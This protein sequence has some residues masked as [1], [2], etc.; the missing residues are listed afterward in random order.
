MITGW[1]RLSR[2]IETH[3]IYKDPIKF[4]WWIDLLINV[5][6]KDSKINIGNQ[7]IEC[8]RGQSIMSLSS[9]GERWGVSK[10]KA[11]N[12]FLLLEKDGMITH[13]NVLKSTR[14]TI[15]NYESYQSDLHDSQTRSKR[16]PNAI[17]TQSHPLEKGEESKKFKKEEEVYRHFAHLTI[18]KTEFDKLIEEGNT[19][20]SIDDVLDSIENYKK[21]K[22]YTSLYLTAKK[23]LKSEREKLSSQPSFKPSENKGHVPPSKYGPDFDPSKQRF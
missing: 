2:S 11:R 7:L 16:K 5:S 13:E 19:K 4:K 6:F 10:D 22:T 18:S 21:N 3:W 23:W 14:I 15:C 17:Q 8:K 20:Q 9:W 1:I 12:F